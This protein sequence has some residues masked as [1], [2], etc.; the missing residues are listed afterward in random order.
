MSLPRTTPT[1]AASR[2]WDRPRSALG[3][4][5]RGLPGCSQLPNGWDSS[6]R[7]AASR[8][9]RYILSMTAPADR[10]AI[11]LA[12]LNPSVGDVTGNADKVR[13][14][15]DIAAEQGADLI[16]FPEL[17]I[18]GYP[19]EDL[20]LKP[21]FQAACRS[22]VE[23]LARETTNGPAVLVGAPWVEDGKLHNTHLLLESGKIA[24]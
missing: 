9:P 11:A 22:A 1:S 15:R 13:R 10:L 21:A 23:E 18:A 20:V 3:S 2:T 24:A 16:I 4:R 12:Q 6:E 8:Q 7:I 19:P 14:A 5:S 17:F